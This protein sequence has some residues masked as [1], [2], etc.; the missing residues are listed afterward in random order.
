MLQRVMGSDID[1]F[2]SSPPPSI[3]IFVYRS[4]F[5]GQRDWK[6]CAAFTKVELVEYLERCRNLN[7]SLAQ[8]IVDKHPTTIAIRILSESDLSD[9][10]FG[11]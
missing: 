8:A 11:I 3:A 1:I 7:K 10:K 9:L 6:F 4:G 5:A 2:K